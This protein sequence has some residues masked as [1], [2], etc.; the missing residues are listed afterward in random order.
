VDGVQ[1]RVSMIYTQPGCHACGDRRAI[2]SQWLVPVLHWEVKIPVVMVMIEADKCILYKVACKSRDWICFRSSI[3][4]IVVGHAVG[5]V[6][7]HARTMV[8][9][10]SLFCKL[11]SLLAVS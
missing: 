6:R 10:F 7:L 4:A 9:L 1:V 3:E 5:G 8:V 11:V 2:N